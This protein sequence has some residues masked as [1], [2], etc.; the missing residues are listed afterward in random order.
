S[1]MLSSDLSAQPLAQQRVDL[2]RAQPVADALQPARV[3][4]GGEPVVQRG[5]PD[6]GLGRLPLGVL[7]AVDTQ[8]CGVRKVRAELEEERPEVGVYRVDVEVVDNPRA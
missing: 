8:P 4:A 6:A 1:G 2:L 7:I 3:I 5:E